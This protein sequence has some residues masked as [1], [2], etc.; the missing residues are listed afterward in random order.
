HQ[1]LNPILNKFRQ[2]LLRPQLR[3][4]LGQAQPKFSLAELFQGRKIV[5]VP[6]NK[7]V[8]GS[9]S[10][11]LIGSLVTSILW[12]LILRQ[13]SVEPSKRQS[14]FI[15]VDETPSF[16]GIPNAN[17]DEALSQSRQFN[18]GWAIGFQHL[19]QMSSNL[20]AGIESN[21]ANKIVFGL[22]LN[23][24]KEMAK[25]TLEVAKEDFYSLPPFWV[26]SRIETSPN[27]YRWVIGKTYPPT[28]RI[29]DSRTP[30]LNSLIK[31]GQNVDDLE[32]EFQTFTYQEKPQT[33]ESLD[34]L[35]R[36]KRSNRSS[37]RVDEEDSS[38]PVK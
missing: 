1:M 25:S 2:F 24:A 26:Y 4:M 36:K 7:A 12:M 31:Y 33:A 29:R 13:S 17:L 30:Y 8:I 16:L 23:E 37:N 10:A 15:Y 21:T 19:A 32:R 3:A 34:D 14:A 22:N 9:E 35:G 11:K 28:P 18:V 20:K 5:L 38:S 6:L 27:T